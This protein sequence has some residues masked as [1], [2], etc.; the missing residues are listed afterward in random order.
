[1]SN[2]KK[3]FKDCSFVIFEK[4]QKDKAL[5]L[6][7]TWIL[8]LTELGCE[9]KNKAIYIDPIPGFIP[10]RNVYFS[11]RHDN[12]LLNMAKKLDI[13]MV[14]TCQRALELLE[15]EEARR[16]KVIQSC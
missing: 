8:E 5:V 14:E 1:M 2:H 10:R 12:T 9:L 7:R 4:C 3:R 13:S 15:E 16:D 11:A 6:E